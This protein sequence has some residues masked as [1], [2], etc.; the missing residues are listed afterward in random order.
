MP[1][2]PQRTLIFSKQ[3]SS[4]SVSIII[5]TG[6]ICIFKSLTKNNL[7]EFTLP[8][9]CNSE[10]NKSKLSYIKFWTLSL[11]KH[12]RAGLL[13]QMESA[14]LVFQDMVI[15]PS[16]VSVSFATSRARCSII[17]HPCQHLLLSVFM[18]F[19]SL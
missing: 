3:M 17:S 8:I 1:I 7:L 9:E 12:L 4:A 5:I 10:Y 15:L 16:R 18:Q 13:G 11:G 6:N 19:W 2:F 14:C